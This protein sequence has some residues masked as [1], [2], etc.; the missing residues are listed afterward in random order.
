MGVA[1]ARSRRW[2]AC[3][4]E[5]SHAPCRMVRTMG[6]KMAPHALVVVL[7]IGIAAPALGQQRLWVET[8]PDG[9]DWSSRASEQ[10][11][12]WQ[13]RAGSA[14]GEPD[15]RPTAPEPVSAG[16]PWSG[17]VPRAWGGRADAAPDPAQP[18]Y[19]FRGDPPVGSRAWN[20]I[21]GSASGADEGYRF[22]PLTEREQGRQTSTPGWRP[23]ERSPAS[24][25]D[26][27]AWTRDGSP[28]L[29]DALTPPPRAYGFEPSPWLGR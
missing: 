12:R 2:I 13:P 23:L 15:W 29:M 17:N 10:G 14:W 28:G 1:A 7:S 20:E 6:L 22:R 3:H 4:A 21:H 19:R 8:A 18:V 9:A 27:Q 25:G 5:A 16:D 24:A 11:A 26:E